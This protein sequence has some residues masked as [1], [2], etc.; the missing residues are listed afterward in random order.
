MP[1]K[2]ALIG[3]AVAFASLLPVSGLAQLNYLYEDRDHDHRYYDREH[4]DYHEWNE[5]EARAY[6]RYWQERHEREIAWER[7]KERQRRD[8]WRW[9]HEHPQW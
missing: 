2:K 3:I 5:R 7:A 6:H 1:L 8:Y 4:R 9:R